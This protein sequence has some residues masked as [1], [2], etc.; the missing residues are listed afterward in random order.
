MN[1]NMKQKIIG[2]IAF[3][4]AVLIL[5]FQSGIYNKPQPQT[6]GKPEVAATQTDTPELIATSPSPLEKSTIWGTTQ[7]TIT[8]NLPLENIPEL[9]YKLEPSA[10]FK[11]DLSPDKKT[12]IFTPVKPLPLGVDYTLSISGEAKFEGKKTLG[13]NYTFHFKTISYNG[14]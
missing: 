10:D 12:V 2:I 8:F 6:E 11:V 5:I 13:K 9:K 7:V 1:L 3:I 14:V 4:G